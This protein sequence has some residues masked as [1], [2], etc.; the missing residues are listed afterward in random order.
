LGIEDLRPATLNVEKYN[1]RKI[2]D[3]A[4]ALISK[5]SHWGSLFTII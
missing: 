2:P 3:G 5:T 1:G 4:S